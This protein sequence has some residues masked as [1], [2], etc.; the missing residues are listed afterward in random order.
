MDE[1]F[2]SFC[3]I[4]FFGYGL[5]SFSK[6]LCCLIK[7]KKVLEIREYSSPI[8]ND[9]ESESSFDLSELSSS[10]SDGYCDDKLKK[11]KRK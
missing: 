6:D 4:F 1:F 9:S 7:P 5:V 10:E 3:L 8:I 11:R 2:I